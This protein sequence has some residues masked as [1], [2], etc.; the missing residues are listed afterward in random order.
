MTSLLHVALLADDLDESL[1]FYREALGFERTYEWTQSATPEGRVVYT[2][3]GALIE[4]GERTYLEQLP[5]EPTNG[6]GPV[7]HIAL[8]V[9]DVD[10]AYQRCLAAGARAF[11]FDGWDGA[12]LTVDL[13][14]TPPARVRDAFV[15]GPSGELLE[16]YESME[17]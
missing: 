7:H 4:L 14:G 2:G 6:T 11:S 5:G 16:L 13:N 8:L 9:P 15:L 3:R 1:R 12:P 17:A 10:E